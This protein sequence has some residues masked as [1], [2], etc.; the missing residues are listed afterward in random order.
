MPEGT[1]NPLLFGSRYSDDNNGSGFLKDVKFR[2]FLITN[3]T[4]T[5]NFDANGR[6]KSYRSD[7]DYK[8]VLSFYDLM[9]LLSA[10]GGGINIYATVI[11]AVN[12]ILAN[13][14]KD[15][16]SA[17]SVLRE[18]ALNIVYHCTVEIEKV[19]F[20]ERPFGDADGDGC[21]SAADARLVLRHAVGLEDIVNAADLII[22]DLNFDGEINAADARLVLRTAVD[23]E[24]LF[25][26]VPSDRQIVIADPE[27]I[28]A[29]EE[30]PIDPDKPTSADQQTE[31]DN[32]NAGKQINE[33]ISGLIQSVFDIIE[34]TKEIVDYAKEPEEEFY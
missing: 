12:M 23:L 8:F 20:N 19:N 15:T 17:D 26:K 9:N 24:P 10:F 34:N 6:L 30:K 33:F 22:S 4:L 25:T 11:S 16:V 14:D 13:L 2:E 21:V 28:T 29:P 7:I 18:R 1:I 5:A 32:G 31:P 3:A 27:K